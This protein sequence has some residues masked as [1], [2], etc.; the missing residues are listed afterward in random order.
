MIIHINSKSQISDIQHDF[1]QLFPF[2]KIE[3]FKY[4]HGYQEASSRQIKL[5]S[6]LYIGELAALIPKEI[7][8]TENMT[9]QQFEKLFEAKL[10]LNI[11][12]F[13]K[14]GSIWLETTMTDSWT[15]KQQNEHG[16][17]ISGDPDS[18]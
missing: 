3:L 9:V 13:R 15:L 1:N 10:G 5:P 17:E 18:H 4:K 7:D 12:V 16:R 11:Q 8:V 14:S 2:L 6:N